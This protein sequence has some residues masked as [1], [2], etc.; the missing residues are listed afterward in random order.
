[1]TGTTHPHVTNAA[2][3]VNRSPQGSSDVSG[4]DS[5]SLAIPQASANDTHAYDHRDQRHTDITT[6]RSHFDALIK[7]RREFWTILLEIPYAQTSWTNV[8]KRIASG[9]TP[10][11]TNLLNAGKQAAPQVVKVLHQVRPL[12]KELEKAASETTQS[13]IRRQIAETLVSIPLNPERALLLAADLKTKGERFLFLESTLSRSTAG[14][15]TQPSSA[16]HNR[17]EYNSLRVTLG[18]ESHLVS[19]DLSS[20]RHA[21]APYVS[22]KSSLYEATA[23][24]ANHYAHTIQGARQPLSD[25]VK[26]ETAIG[27]LRAIE[28]YSPDITAPFPFHARLWM[29]AQVNSSHIRALTPIRIPGHLQQ[30]ARQMHQGM[31]DG[32]R[33]LRPSEI[34]TMHGLAADNATAL[35]RLIHP[36][37]P[38]LETDSFQSEHSHTHRA[39]ISAEHILEHNE[40]RERLLRTV[41]ALPKEEATAISLRYGLTGS[42]EK[43]FR[44]IGK[45]LRISEASAFRVVNLALRKLKRALTQ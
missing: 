10:S 17:A 26:Q 14:T 32:D 16:D 24:L 38:I 25:D 12:L 27:L 37:V 18:R 31:S 3:M 39:Q 21:A 9:D 8:L 36:T 11:L 20:L 19:R 43:T 22:L 45:A 4:Y 40:E 42:D 29:R 44:E 6:L 30:I 41:S 13:S 33:F 2:R 7:A 35:E 34:A 23:Y 5:S 28:R 15:S 1:M